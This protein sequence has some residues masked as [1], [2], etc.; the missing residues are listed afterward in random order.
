MIDEFIHN[1][2]LTEI[3]NETVKDFQSNSSNIHFINYYNYFMGMRVTFNRAELV[4]SSNIEKTG[5]SD[6]RASNYR[7]NPNYKFENIMT[8]DFGSKTVLKQLK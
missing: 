7:L 1:A 8:N 5:K 6:Y 4:N 2:I 3:F